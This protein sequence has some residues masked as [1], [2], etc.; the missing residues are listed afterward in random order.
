MLFKL[1]ELVRPYV[2]KILVVIEPLLIDEDYYARVEGR[3][4]RARVC[5]AGG[6]CSW[7]FDSLSSQAAAVGCGHSSSR[8][9][10][11]HHGPFFLPAP[12]LPFAGRSSPTLPRQR[13]WPP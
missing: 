6:V 10:L 11:A 12:L 1:D 4:V 5:A 2:H 3:C 7:L 9:S 8:R 13:D